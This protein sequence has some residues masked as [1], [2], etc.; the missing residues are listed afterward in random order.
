MTVDPTRKT[1]RLQHGRSVPGGRLDRSSS[2]FAVRRFLVLSST[3]TA[4]LYSVAVPRAEA[5][6]STDEW[7]AAGGT[8]EVSTTTLTIREG[9]VRSYRLRLTR[10]LPR[11]PPPNDD[12]REEGWWVRLFVDGANRSDG[13]YDADGDGQNDI[14]WAPGAGWDFDPSDWPADGMD[15]EDTDSYWRDVTI[16]ALEDDDEEDATIVFRHE[17][18][19]HDAYC[20]DA[21][22]P[23]R[24]PSVT[25]RVIDDDGPN[26]P[27]PELSIGDATVEEGGTARFEVR[28]DTDS[29][30]DVTVRYRTSN[31]TAQAGSD[32]EAV[33]D[34][35]TIEAGIRS[36]F[37]SVPTTEDAVYEGVETF[38][39][40]LSSPD[41]A[42]LGDAA[43]EGTITDDDDP[44]TLSIGNATVDEGDTAAF[45]VTLSGERAVTAT[46][47]YSTMDG[48]AFAGSDYTA[49]DGGTLTFRPGDDSETIRVRTREDS[50]REDAEYFTVVLSDPREATIDTGTGTGTIDD[51]DA[52]ALPSL[53][54]EDTTVTEGAPASFE[55]TL[56]AASTDTVTVEYVTADGTA[57]GDDDYTAV[58]TPAT[59]T[60][61]PQ[62]RSETITVATLQDQDY[63][64]DE[65]FTVRLSSPSM[66]TID[67]GTATGTIE[68]ND[69]PGISINDV[70]VREGS[71]AQ[72]T[73]RLEGPTDHAV[74]VTAATSDGTAVAGE[75]YRTKSERLTIPAR[76]TTAIFSVDTIADG[77]QDSNETF[78]VTLSNPSGATLDDDTGTGTITEGGGGGGGGRTPRRLS[79][80]DVSVEE[81]AA[82]EFT[83][84][85]SRTS[86][87]I[88]TVEVATSDGT[89][90]A[91]ND[92]TAK[93][94]TLSIP[95]GKT[96][97]TFSVDTIDDQD[98]E[99]DEDFTVTLSNPTGATLRDDTGTGT[100]TANDGGG[101]A[102]PQLSIADAAAVTEGETARF[103]VTLTGVVDQ[104]V[105]VGFETGDGSATADDD[106]YM[107][108]SGTLTFTASDTTQTISVVTIDDTIREADESFTVT[109]SNPVGA[110][111][112]GGSATGTITDNDDTALP[113]LSIDDADPVTEGGT[114]QFA[115]TLSAES[116]QVVT[117]SYAT[118]DGTAAEGSD[119]T[120]ATAT[121][122]FQP[123]ERTKTIPVTTI[124]DTDQESQEQFTVSLSGPVGATLDR[125]TGTGTIDD[126]DAPGDLPQLSIEDAAAEEGETVQFT[127]TLTGNSNQNVTV[128]FETADGTALAGSD[129]EQTSGTLTFPPGSETQTIGVQSLE[130]DAA[131]S[132]ETFT[133]RLS[134]PDGATIE[135]GTAQG[136]IRDDDG[137][138]GT[139]PVLTIKD[140]A[141]VAEGETA[142]FPVTLSSPSPQPVTVSYATADGTA[143][144]GSD[145][146][147]TTGTLRF[148][149]GETA[150]TI[151]VPALDDEIR[152]DTEH[153]TVELSDPVG[154]TL[155][156]ATGT[157]SI[158]DDDED[159]LPA[160]S[161][162][163][164]DPVTE[165]GTAQFEVTLSA[166]S[167]QVVTVSYA[168]A[169]GTAT[170]GSDYAAATATLSFQPGERTKTIPVTTIDDDELESEEHFTVT[171]SDPTGATLDDSSGRG[172]ITD[173][174]DDTTPRLSI[175]DASAAEGEN[176]EF[177]VVL[178][179]SPGETVTVD[180]ETADGTALAGSDYE[181]TSGTLTFPPGSETQTIGVQSLEDDA[182]ESDETFTVR[183]RDPDGATI[184]DGT[185]Q[186]TIRD[187]DGG[188]GTLPVLTIKDAAPVAEG[189]TASFPVTL[190]SPNSQV[191]TVSYATADGTARAGSDYG[192]TT[193]TL[194]FEPGETA[195]TIR[196]PALDDE[197]RED[198]EHFTVELSDPVRAT[199]V[200]AAG[201]GS[202]TDDDEDMLPALSIADAAPVAE[203]VTALFAVTLSAAT[204]E[205]V[206][207]AFAT[208]DGTAVDAADYAATA[209]TLT[210]EPGTTRQ[211][212][213]VATLEDDVEE[214]AEDFTVELSDPSG[215]TL[216]DDT[217][218]GTITDNDGGSGAL[219]EVSIGDAVAVE[220]GTAG[221]EVT[222]RPA[223]GQ[224]VTVRYRTLDG[225]AHE[226]ADYSGADGTLRFEPGQESLTIRVPVLDDDIR[227]DTETFTVELSDPA[228]AAVAD[229]AGVGTITDND[230]ARLP[231]LSAGDAAP[232]V[233]G[234]TA[235]IPVTLS[236]ASEQVVTVAFA[237]ADGS[238]RAGADY[239]A[240][241]G[242][243]TFRPGTRRQTIAVATRQDEIVESE[244]TFTVAL[245]DPRG[246]T[247]EDDAGTGTITDDDLMDDLPALTVG[248]AAPVPEGVAATFIVTLGP[249]SERTV[250]VSYRTVDGTATAG[251]DYVATDGTLRFE[252]G[253]TSRT[254][255]VTT[256][257]D[258]LLEGTE[259]F[260]VE[261]SEPVA[262]TIADGTGVGTI[263]E[264]AERIAM[265]NRTVLPELGRALAFS[266]VRCRFE[267][268]LSEPPARGGSQDPAG[269]LSL[270]H[271]L[272][273]DRQTTPGQ[274]SLTLERALGDSSFFLPMQDEEGDAGRFAAWGCGD[275]RYLGG[276]GAGGVAWDGEAFSVNVGADV[277]LGSNALAGLSVSRSRGSFDYRAG[278]ADGQAGGGAYDL[279]LT[280]VH[281]YLGWSV[282]PGLDVWGTVGHAWGELRIMDRLVAGP[283]T[284]AAT[285]D[286][287]AAGVSGRLVERGA[288]R[289]DLKGEAALAR[290]DIAGDGALIEAMAVNMR[291]LRLSTE[292][293]RELVFS[294]GG[295][296]TPWGELGLRHD[297]GD[298]ETGA[299]LEVGGGLRY[300]TPGAGW[301]TE[302]YGRWLAAHEGALREWG[303]GAVIRY[304][305]GASG[306]GPSVSLTP[307]WG[308]TASGVQRLWERGATDPTVPRPPGSRL[309]AQ[310]GYGL[311]AF[312]GRGVLIPFGRVSLD[313]E[314]GNGYRIGSRIA[315]DRSANLSLEVERRERAAAPA[316]YAILVRGAWQ[317]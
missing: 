200:G 126:N 190:S 267:R 150:Q 82:A 173:D 1:A 280:G 207:V 244:E 61:T 110:T 249:V 257:A 211:T 89:A 175:V 258:E 91:G 30:R 124:D 222:L 198:T 24:L 220:G 19:D 196:V 188:G 278:G 112:A 218:T 223:A 216:E 226:G 136:T 101:G 203:G 84:T 139:L 251:P 107:P 205:A 79:I 287:G 97:V 241:S 265:V 132:D 184:E 99:S 128:D 229:G 164:A 36:A 206:T 242:T 219:P 69:D 52:G 215:A 169:D 275:Y 301:T 21:M 123:G 289:L 144:A 38:T 291:R 255:A 74:S 310:F 160:L 221:F 59:L 153:F 9:E 306:R 23:D 227:E 117:V 64:G 193:G 157:G 177:R 284:S 27:K 54:I 12:Q 152:E 118:A 155:V 78:T 11:R 4:L 148:A 56:S 270:P 232:V 133:I 277:R 239:D 116:Q 294:S 122:T 134:D 20:P 81:G 300:Q 33:D 272:T 302:G 87:R 100:I 143:R 48:T 276:G 55:V 75:D 83:V 285:L 279:R 316:V 90:E 96:E 197:I 39:V 283:L 260:T 247:I 304:D 269:Y 104:T 281:P 305:P 245:S 151:R 254:I 168:T 243:L 296:L 194:T 178:T 43:G 248:D 35:L 180:F 182:A 15:D 235:R 161:I 314:Y 68:D 32:Y 202:I 137:G 237:T 288:T 185:A 6:N 71:T 2:A 62:D 228:G 191:V 88:V 67:D 121:L 297:D 138:G 217:G 312:R 159:M 127:V 45:E 94:E 108:A 156:G 7:V 238:A 176:V 250:S 299:G 309:D 170:E 311:A 37:I 103:A 50:A 129:Y 145:Y 165:G 308:D 186:G 16:R 13:F 125:D 256:L 10:R 106:D 231:A 199:L 58:T 70:T 76:R 5:Q 40:R 109:L 8:V 252:P 73:V 95:A 179:G 262:A 271:T 293:S 171:L 209:G 282:S 92:Y 80:D 263:T 53:R 142:S 234:G 253:E 51:D 105:T 3:L 208:A 130:D 17:L 174:D 264:V 158:T 230:D 111:I 246:A 268:G 120:A 42:T 261:L 313:R 183:L 72:F 114:A 303:F 98:P 44:P 317:F 63:E 233:E 57:R 113:A 286:S 47:R 210:L 115:V 166:A 141:P 18:W 315:V 93:S 162:A 290:L 192:S 167:R 295:S 22:H 119:Y 224:A 146:A 149:P 85:L 135:D 213:E 240:T 102:G 195:Q 274:R 273:S 154:A 34:T 77:V 26:A 140:A 46:V 29:E 181:Q 131:E 49:I 225:T 66:A 163:D 14:G 307:G 298:G 65:T 147:S 41:R 28:L 214:P 172:A 212:I 25:V 86:N 259:R 189:E 292:A 60:F 201:T 266:T 31:G 187:D 236:A 204:A